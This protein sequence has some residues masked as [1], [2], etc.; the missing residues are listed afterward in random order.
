VE[1]EKREKQLKNA[2]T[3]FAW[4]CPEFLS[5]YYMPYQLIMPV[6]KMLVVEKGRAMGGANE[7]KNEK[8]VFYC[9]EAVPRS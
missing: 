2:H 6:G 5:L 8:K 4:L 9:F 1:G 7:R 3:S